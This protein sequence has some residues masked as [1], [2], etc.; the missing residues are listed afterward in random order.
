ML[1]HLSKIQL[2]AISLLAILGASFLLSSDISA[3]E[4]YPTQSK[5]F[6]VNDLANVVSEDTENYI[7]DCNKKLSAP[8]GGQIVVMTVESLDGESI[9]SY[10]H[11]VFNQYG[12]GASDRNNG[13]LILLSV[14]DRQS[15]IE[16]GRGAEGFITDAGSGRIQDNLM[17][18]EY[19]N[20]NWDAGLKKGFDAILALY[21]KEYEVEISEGANIYDFSYDSNSDYDNLEELFSSSIVFT[22]ISHLFASLLGNDKK[23]RTRR[24][25]IGIFIIVAGIIAGIILKSLTVGMISASIGLGILLSSSKASR[26]SYSGGSSGGSSFG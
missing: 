5:E 26:S 2:L 8:T 10:A 13:T 14:G 21:E 19:K 17:I 4:S 9:E 16:V 6:Y 24:R 1:K 11:G 20:G 12:I 23:S 7:I 15:R 22:V 3:R 25:Y 18:P